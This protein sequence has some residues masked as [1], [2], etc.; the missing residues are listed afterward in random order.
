[1]Y[2]DALCHL[3]INHLTQ[4]YFCFFFSYFRFFFIF[5]EKKIVFFSCSTAILMEY[6]NIN[7]VCFIFLSFSLSFLFSDFILSFVAVARAGFNSVLMR[8]P[9]DDD[10]NDDD[11]NGCVYFV[12]SSI[13]RT[14]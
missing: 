7:P 10:D 8:L 3:T 14:T 6:L 9:C 12:V 13:M 1:M 2:D 4:K 11:D 5:N